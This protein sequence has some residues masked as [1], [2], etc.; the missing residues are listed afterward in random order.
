MHINRPL[1]EVQGSRA[2]RSRARAI[3]RPG[4]HVRRNGRASASP[5]TVPTPVVEET[6]GNSGVLREPRPSYEGVG[7]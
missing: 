6:A 2:A 3:T 7:T 1:T 4:R 5:S